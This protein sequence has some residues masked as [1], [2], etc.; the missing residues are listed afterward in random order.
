MANR[1]LWLVLVLVSTACGLTPEDR[2]A[3]EIGQ[4]PIAVSAEVASTSFPEASETSVAIVKVDPKDARVIAAASALRSTPLELSLAAWAE[5]T[6]LATSEGEQYDSVES[7]SRRASS[8]VV[9][10]VL[11]PGPVRRLPRGTVYESLQVEVLDALA[12]TRSLEPGDHVRVEMPHAPHEVKGRVAVFF[13][14]CNQDDSDG[15]LNS[16][17][18]ASE[19]GIFRL[20]GHQGVFV[21]RGDGVPINPIT[22]AL[23]LLTGD[24]DEVR[25]AEFV[26]IDN[27]PT[28]RDQP[29]AVQ[30]RRLTM[31]EFLRT[32][33]AAGSH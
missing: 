16:D 20:L 4:E 19:A 12:G 32:V 13:L 29:V 18:P 6:V 8:V 30:A 1:R 2:A 27:A 10:K 5:Q 7:M 22:E 21:D 9:G 26:F 28:R 33:I 14:R 25:L 17:V 31:E 24:E 11:G 23:L 3:R 15:N